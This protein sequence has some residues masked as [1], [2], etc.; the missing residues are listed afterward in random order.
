MQI[1]IRVYCYRHVLAAVYRSES[2]LSEIQSKRVLP[3]QTRALL[4]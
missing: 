2:V 3:K 4:Q 1:E